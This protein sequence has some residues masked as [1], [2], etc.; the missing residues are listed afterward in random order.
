M[1]L[2]G[3]Q[4]LVIED[5]PDM[6][7]VLTV[8]I[9]TII[10]AARRPVKIVVITRRAPQGLRSAVPRCSD[11]RRSA[12]G[13]RSNTSART[14]S[15]RLNV[16]AVHPRSQ[17][18]ELR[19]DRDYGCRRPDCRLADRFC[20]EGGGYGPVGDITLGVMGGVGGGFVLW[21]QGIAQARS[22]LVIVA[23]AFAGAFI[24]I[25]VQRKFWNVETVATR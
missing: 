16:P 10:E 15:P 13:P 19:N 2:K 14:P 9:R 21:M 1:G 25:V 18:H 8:L 3:L 4:V 17:G 24:L 23:A 22:W 7:G 6:L 5:A 12:I 11:R 20:H